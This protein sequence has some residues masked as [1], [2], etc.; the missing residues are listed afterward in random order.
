M[1]CATT[2]SDLVLVAEGPG[3]VLEGAAGPLRAPSQAAYA[4]AEP[5]RVEPER[6]QH[7]IEERLRFRHPR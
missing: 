7:S 5:D 6:A 4:P 2:A 1:P 3:P